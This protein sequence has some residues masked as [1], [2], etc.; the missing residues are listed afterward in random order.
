[1][2]A[3]KRE[4]KRQMKHE[5]PY[6]VKMYSNNDASLMYEDPMA[7]QSAPGFF[8]GHEFKGAKIKVEMAEKK[9]APPGGW[10]A[11]GGSY[12]GRG[13]GRGGGGRG[14]GRGGGGRGGGG[15]GGYGG[16]Y[17]RY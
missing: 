12:G 6:A 17:N 14:Y 5:W 9:A 16:G 3:K 13:G 1:M 7:A 15:R 11:G 10:S 4:H 8:N 2:I